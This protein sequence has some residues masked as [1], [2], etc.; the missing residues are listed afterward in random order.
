MRKTFTIVGVLVL[1]LFGITLS[2]VPASRTTP[3]AVL[4]T[5]GD[6]LLFVLKAVAD[7]QTGRSERRKQLILLA[8]CRRDKY[9]YNM[10]SPTGQ[11]E[12]LIATKQA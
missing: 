4:Q 9:F 6:A 8:V 1:L 5:L 3:V 2:I 7:W 11:N 10:N 12:Q